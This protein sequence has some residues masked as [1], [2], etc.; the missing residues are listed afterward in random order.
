MYSSMPSVC[1]FDREVDDNMRIAIIGGN[2]TGL[3][4]SHFLLDHDDFDIFIFEERAEIGFPVIGSGLLINY[5][6]HF[7]V[8]NSW[9]SKMTFPSE[10]F[11]DI[12]MVFHRGWLEKDL[13]LSFVSRGGKISVR[14]IANI[15]SSNTLS[16]IGAG[17][18]ETIWEGDMIIDLTLDTDSSLIG[19]FS[20]SPQSSG[21][22]RSD[23][24][25]ETWFS[26]NSEIPDDTIEIISSTSK[27]FDSNTIDYSIIQSQ[28]IYHSIIE[29]NDK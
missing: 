26:F 22:K 1:S 11:N 19:V 27:D 13:S 21:W 14:T 24:V 12:G 7:N 28:K 29:S 18:K 10:I 5:S 3:F 17:G 15:D 2:L 9:I 20:L 4:L 16:L 25:W 23:G 6:E 8:I